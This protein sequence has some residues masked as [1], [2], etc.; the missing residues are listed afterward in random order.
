LKQNRLTLSGLTLSSPV[1]NVAEAGEHFSPAHRRVRQ[2]MTIRYS[3]TIYNAIQ[4][5]AAAQPQLRTQMLIFRDGKQVYAGTA[6]AFDASAQT[7]PKR[8][9]AGGRLRISPELTPGQYVL[10]VLVTDESNKDK[11]RTITQSSDFEV[12]D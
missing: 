6:L 4:D 7:D 8:L 11:P 10:Q 5:R 1:Q 3:Y 9:A 2:G 12:V